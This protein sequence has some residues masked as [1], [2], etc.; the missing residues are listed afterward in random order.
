M[1]R[2]FKPEEEQIGNRIVVKSPEHM[3]NVWLK[4]NPGIKIIDWRPFLVS[5]GASGTDYYIT[6]QFEEG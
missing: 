6:V 1:F 4:E 2:T 5:T 3:I